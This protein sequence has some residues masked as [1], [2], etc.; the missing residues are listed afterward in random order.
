M[1]RERYRDRM[2][3]PALR[4]LEAI[5]LCMG[6]DSKPLDRMLTAFIAASLAVAAERGAKISDRDLDGVAT[7]AWWAASQELD[8]LEN[9]RAARKLKSKPK[10]RAK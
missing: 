6:K 2:R 5:A 3:E 8:A 7:K 4:S 1:T 9:K 10:A